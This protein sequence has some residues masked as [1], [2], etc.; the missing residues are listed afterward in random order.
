[1]TDF[2]EVR[3][4]ADLFTKI[5]GVY[6]FYCSE[7]IDSFV[8]LM[9]GFCL[10][11]RIDPGDF[12]DSV[13]TSVAL[14]FEESDRK[15]SWRE[16]VKKNAVVPSSEIPLLYAAVDW[17]DHVVYT[18]AWVFEPDSEWQSRFLAEQQTV[19]LGSKLPAPDR[20]VA[21]EFLDQ[22]ALLF[23]LNSAGVRYAEESLPSVDRLMRWAKSCLAVDVEAWIEHESGEF[24]RKPVPR[25][26]RD[27]HF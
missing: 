9:N 23:Y 6:R 14:F 2:G 25:E 4:V 22:R 17:R 8:A 26:D 13:S 19:G 20:L 11:M 10:A 27:N 3:S 21:A 15:L 18:K 5:R 7:G 1:M 16:I 24:N 12:W